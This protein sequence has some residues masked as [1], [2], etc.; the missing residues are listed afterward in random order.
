MAE[1]QFLRVNDYSGGWTPDLA[2]ILLQENEAQLIENF[3]IDKTG[4][5]V[6]RKGNRW[7]AQQTTSE[8][9]QDFMRGVGRWTHPTDPTQNKIITAYS[10]GFWF[11]SSSTAIIPLAYGVSG[12]DAVLA[13]GQFSS[14]QEGLY[15]TYKLGRPVVYNGNLWY[16]LGIVQPTSAP[17]IVSISAGSMT[18][19]YKYVYS[20]LDTSLG[21]GQP[22]ESNPSSAVTLDTTS[23]QATIRVNNSTNP[24]ISTIRI[25]RTLAGGV[26]LLFLKDLT[27]NTAGGTQ[28]T[29]DANGA[30]AQLGPTYDNDLAPTDYPLS[31]FYK[32]YM[33]LA[34]GTSLKW[35]K[36][37]Q[38]DSWPALQEAT[39]T[40]EGSDEITALVPFQDS[41]LIFG[42]HSLLVLVGES[43]QWQV[44]PISVNLG[45]Y[46]HKTVAHIE[47]GLIFL[48]Q[49]GLIS[50][51]GLEPFGPKLSRTL[52]AL[53]H[54]RLKE[55]AMVYVPEEESIWLSLDDK[56]Y[57]VNL[58]TQSVSVYTFGA[59]QY[60]QGGLTGAQPP[61]FVVR[62]KGRV[63]EYAGYT[64]FG[65][66]KI[67]ARWVSKE[68]QLEQP[69]LTK[70]FRRIG[71]ILDSPT[72]STVYVTVRTPTA[73]FTALLQ[74]AGSEV[75]SVLTWGNSTWG[76]SIWGGRQLRQFIAALPAQT[77]VSQTF[78]LEIS[79]ELTSELAVM[80][81]ITV[82]YR[83]A[84]R[85]LGA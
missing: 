75:D 32:G 18:G 82:Q 55:S 44:S 7:W 13:G 31:S 8:N 5:L 64:D 27:N 48:S 23:G 85:F 15:Y 47:G 56:T 62:S 38:F 3:R 65:G 77:L 73:T 9:T 49:D 51:P 22:S 41:L 34:K 14:F 20:Y 58:L 30:V 42:R 35:S 60:I 52:R 37:L 50:Y 16:T 69:E 25:Y 57:T 1:K 24:R 67:N 78:A 79:S 54:A 80:P 28:D 76:E 84:N 81:P 72:G 45:T 29:V 10:S 61:L 68:F 70:Y 43:G 26:Q 63:R 36:P 46:S 33:F 4:S 6:S 21:D 59:L 83:Q 17:G 2:P 19:V 74:A 53:S 12:G 66:I 71:S 40:F 39:I 11:N